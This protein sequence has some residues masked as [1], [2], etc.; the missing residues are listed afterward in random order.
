MYC[1]ADRNGIQHMVLCRVI[2][3]N[4]ETIDPGSEQFHP[5]S[6]DFESGANDFHN[7]RFY[8]VW[9]MNM[10][11]HIYPEFVVVSRSLTMP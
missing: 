4:I 2:L 9:T 7:S 5:S 1:V 10:N 8:T 6:E 11:T 3:G